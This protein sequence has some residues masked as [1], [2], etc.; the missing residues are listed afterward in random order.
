MS[1]D[2]KRYPAV[3]PKC[4][5]Q[6]YICKSILMEMGVNIG[7]G[8]CTKCRTLHHIQFNEQEQRMD[9]T[10]LEDYLRS[11]KAAAGSRRDDAEQIQDM[12]RGE[13]ADA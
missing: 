11:L 12:D 13:D 6:L 10:P 7:Q 5:R 3:C 9:L 8:K 1:E 2:G 4:R